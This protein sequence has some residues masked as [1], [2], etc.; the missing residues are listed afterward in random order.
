MARKVSKAEAVPS[1][2]L[3]QVFRH[4]HAEK[5]GLASAARKTLANKSE[6]E[7]LGK[8][9]Q[10]VSVSTISKFL[11]NHGF[12]ASPDPFLQELGHL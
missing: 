11:N 12:L 10:I 5:R 6:G 7:G 9:I 2:E 3:L 4:F 1:T 8:Q